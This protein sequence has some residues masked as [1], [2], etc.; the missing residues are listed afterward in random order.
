M[1][2]EQFSTISLNHFRWLNEPR[3]WNL[4]HNVLK[5][6]TDNKTDF[7]QGTW[8]NFH[9]NTGHMFGIDIKDDFTFQ[10]RLIYI[11]ILP[12]DST[13][14]NISLIFYNNIL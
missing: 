10:V 11:S 13:N 5:V 6:T 14:Y 8:Y 9:F 12:I 4:C 1:E 7:W 3:N 2:S